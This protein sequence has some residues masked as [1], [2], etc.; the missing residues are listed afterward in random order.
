[1]SRYTIAVHHGDQIDRTATVGYDRMLRTYFLQA[2]PHEDDGCRYWL[3]CFLE[4]YP[5][6]ESLQQHAREC[7][8][9]LDGI[10]DEMREAMLT[11]AS[12]P[13]RRSI[14]EVLGLAR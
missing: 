9:R 14:G 11:E 13:H 4:E 7:G 2:F 12:Q 6:L 10:T 3:G 5:T 8:L 1:M